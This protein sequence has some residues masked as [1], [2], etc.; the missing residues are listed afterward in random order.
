MTQMLTHEA[1]SDLSQALYFD[2]ISH[3]ADE[4]DAYF[5]AQAAREQVIGTFLTSFLRRLQAF[6]HEYRQARRQVEG[7]PDFIG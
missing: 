6:S 3:E 4:M 7:R 5:G 1:E 2:V